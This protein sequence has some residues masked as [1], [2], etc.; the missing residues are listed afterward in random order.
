MK[1]V[2]TNSTIYSGKEIRSDIAILINEGKIEG[3]VYN[4]DIPEDYSLID[5]K[6]KNICPAFIDLQIY[7]A[8]G[9]LF[10]A[11]PSIE[12]INATHQYCLEGGATKFLLTIA[13]NSKEIVSKGISVAK[14]YLNDGGRGLHGLHLE[15]PWINPEKRG[16][17]LK[18]HICSPTMED[19]KK[20]IE[21]AE[22]IVKMITLAPE[23]VDE[24]ILDYLLE[25]E[26]LVS[27]GHSN[28]S[29]QQAATGFKKIKLATHLFNAMSPLQS[30]EPG[31]VGAIYNN[32][33]V[34]SSFVADGI[35]VDFAALQI[36]KKILGDRLFLITDA[37]AETT[38]GAYQHVF[39]NDR[40]TI[41]DGTLSGSA[42]NMMKAVKNCVRHANIEL[43]EALRMASLYPARILGIDNEFGFIERNYQTSLA[44]FDNELNLVNVIDPS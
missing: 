13:T 14:K 3:F 20:L 1:Q 7:G 4:S 38:S 28:A 43:E 33:S 12:A 26:I 11:D 44:V 23:M 40:Y 25:N 6:E 17:H 21:E 9:Y 10:S 42:L 19:V 27:A 16:A 41:P 30:R 2:I 31:M 29:Y 39:K 36:S 15:G 8:N 18:E 35:H 37:V 34:S 24:E 32:D 5:L 22:G